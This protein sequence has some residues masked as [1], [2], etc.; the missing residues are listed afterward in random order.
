L[1]AQSP[2]FYPEFGPQNNRQ[3]HLSAFGGPGLAF[4]GH[5]GFKRFTLPAGQILSEKY[6]RK[7]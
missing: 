4:T 7:C 1:P 2:A 6:K 3:L 5:K